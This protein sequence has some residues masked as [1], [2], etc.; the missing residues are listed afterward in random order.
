[1]TISVKICGLTDTKA[2]QA[3]ITAKA[4]YAGFVYFPASPRH[5]GVHEAANL[6]IRLPARIQSVSVLVD[7][8]DAL[9][10]EV[11]NVFKPDFVQLH[12]SETSERLRDIRHRF[13]ALKIIKALKISNSDDVAQAGHYASSAD[14]LMFDTKPPLLPLPSGEGTYLP[15]GNGLAFDWALLKG[16]E[17]PLPWM[18]SGGLC[19]DNVAEAVRQTGAKIVD[20]SS[21]VES[22]PGVKD[23]ALIHAFTQRARSFV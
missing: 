9:L 2:I 10:A 3:V 19:V 4:D 17:F 8:D 14:M 21:G 6:K 1:M 16:R 15:G 23:P 11:Y 7:P 13:P 18:L 20:V 12:G 5:I 22:A